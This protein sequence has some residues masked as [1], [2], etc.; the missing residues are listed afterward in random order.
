MGNFSSRDFELSGRRGRL[1]A[2]H[3]PN[4]AD[5]PSSAPGLLHLAMLTSLPPSPGSASLRA[6][7]SH[8]RLLSSTFTPGM[9]PS[10]GPP[11]PATCCTPRSLTCGARGTQP[12][13]AA[14]L[15]LA[16]CQ[17]VNA[18]AGAGAEDQARGHPA[19]VPS[20]AH[21]A[22]GAGAQRWARRGRL[23]SKRIPT[24]PERGPAEEKGNGLEL[25]LPETALLK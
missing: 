13:P 20:A 18:I 7:E 6:R 21:A 24:P 2:L 22:A 15:P 23:Q 8:E 14:V 5:D 4:Q 25:L 1:R 10:P 12:K 19:H 17:L 3:A 11:S 9:T 16:P